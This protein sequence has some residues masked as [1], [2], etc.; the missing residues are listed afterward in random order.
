MDRK[1]PNGIYMDY[2]STTPV[3]PG[4]AEAMRPYFGEV[5]GNPASKAH[6]F[7]RKAAEAVE[8][9][10]EQTAALIG[11]SAGEM[12]FTSGATESC[13]L[14]IKGVFEAYRRR[15][16]HI[17]TSAA[18]HRAVIDTCGRLE[19]RGAKVTRLLPDQY[20]RISPEQVAEA[21]TDSTILVSVMLANNEVGTLN[22]I[23]QIGR[24]CK[25]RK[26]LMHC[27]ATQA[28]GKIP[29]DVERMGVD[30]LSLSAHK[31]YGPKGIG[32]LYVRGRRP[33]VRLEPQIDGGGHERGMRSGTVNVPGA[34]GM[35]AAAEICAAE[36][37]E[38]AGRVG[39]LRQQ[40]RD[41]LVGQIQDVRINGHETERLP[42]TLNVSFAHVEGH[43]VVLRMKDV[44]V[45]TGSACGSETQD[46]SHV[47]RAMGVSDDLANGSVRFSLGRWTTPDEVDAAIA[48]CV[49]AVTELRKLSIVRPLRSAKE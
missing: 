25:E 21:I 22:P 1:Y 34:V 49:T 29:V 6:A 14:A 4:V 8:N 9:A 3:D 39:G 5:F 19:E 20:G 7:G 42:N 47:L 30:L 27:D 15:G 44:A 32:A 31:F 13:N 45:S 40:L 28:V 41:G 2:N 38:E 36:M 43:A 33:R 11:A 16:D 37:A 26:V 48:R 18:E 46:P 23:D 24:V 17:V 10:R 35:G 12:V